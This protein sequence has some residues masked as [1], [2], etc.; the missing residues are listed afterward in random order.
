MKYRVYYE[1]TD[2]GGIVYHANYLKFCERARS[3]W[4]YDNGL[5][6]ATQEYHFI[7]KSIKAEFIK[8]ARLGDILEVSNTVLEVG[9]A[10]LK[11][12]QRIECNGMEIYT[13]E[14]VVVCMKGERIRRLPE[15]IKGFLL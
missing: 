4:F 13:Q 8:P 9:S 5:S 14:V 12:F 6:P 11:I 2:M 10:S 15:E 1:D 3:D 7:V